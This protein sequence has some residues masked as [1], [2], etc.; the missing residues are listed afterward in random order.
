MNRRILVPFDGSDPATIA[1][2][3]AL[4]EHPEAAITMLHVLDYRSGAA[5]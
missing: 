3:R 1:L 5:E 2:D 4:E